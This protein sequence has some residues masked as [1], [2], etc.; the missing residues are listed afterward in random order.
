MHHQNCHQKHWNCPII[1][2]CIEENM[3]PFRFRNYV[4]LSSLYIRSESQGWTQN[5]TFLLVQSLKSASRA[6]HYE[7]SLKK[8][9][10]FLLYHFMAFTWPRAP[11]QEKDTYQVGRP[12]CN[13]LGQSWCS[14]ILLFW[15]NPYHK[16]KVILK[17]NLLFLFLFHFIFFPFP[18]FPSFLVELFHN[19]NNHHH[20]HYTINLMKCKLL[21]C[22]N[23]SNSMLN[24]H[25]KHKKYLCL[26]SSVMV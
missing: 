15:W 23:Y 20:H 7:S 5:W 2:R 22:Y 3:H 6:L 10:I 8:K 9:A 11:R 19:D 26:C 25:E 18:L 1:I 14:K 17:S 4:M 21:Q 24:L 13:H 16:I 12:I